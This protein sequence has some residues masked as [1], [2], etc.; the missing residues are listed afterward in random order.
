MACACFPPSCL[1]I[2]ALLYCSF[3]IP[4]SDED[5]PFPIPRKRYS[6]HYKGKYTP[7]VQRRFRNSHEQEGRAGEAHI[8]GSRHNG[9]EQ[10]IQQEG[11]QMK[12]DNDNNVDLSENFAHAREEM[13]RKYS[14]EREDFASTPSNVTSVGLFEA[15]GKFFGFTS[16]NG[17]NRMKSERHHSRVH[18]KHDG[19]SF[20]SE[21]PKVLNA[22]ND[23][24]S[25]A[26]EHHHQMKDIDS[27]ASLSDSAEKWNDNS[28][29]DDIDITAREHFEE[30]MDS[31]RMA[32]ES[33]QV[34]VS[35]SRGKG[36][37]EYLSDVDLR[38]MV[39]LFRKLFSSMEKSLDDSSE[40]HSSRLSTNMNKNKKIEKLGAQD[41]GAEGDTSHET[42]E[43]TSRMLMRRESMPNGSLRE[44]RGEPLPDVR[45][46]LA[47]AESL[48][49]KR[50]AERQAKLISEDA[51]DDIFEPQRRETQ[52]PLRVKKSGNR[53]EEEDAPA[54]SEA[55]G[56][57]KGLPKSAP[58]Y[59]M[60]K[61]LLRSHRRTDEE[62]PEEGLF[63]RVAK[64]VE[65]Y[66]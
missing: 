44:T 25:R 9:A 32:L 33:E 19:D 36:A 27:S 3:A 48:N 46:A 58:A 1:F 50:D 6:P 55:E 17:K 16:N 18:D 30:D 47:A 59:G 45:V 61:R 28:R 24:Y 34:P 66:F 14:H 63:E 4:L 26:K 52:L 42:E 11:A 10:D 22:E 53:E 64:G 12:L 49:E 2:F 57:V 23:S 15:I 8:H 54:D 56:A 40:G 29:D 62:R 20:D 35:L 13:H 21:E 51:E 60:R 41:V 37:D 65:T 43:L 39:R 38:E 7:K 31:A 5:E